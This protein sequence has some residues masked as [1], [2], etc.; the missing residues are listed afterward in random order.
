MGYVAF[1]IV[2]LEVQPGEF[3]QIL[4]ESD[5]YWFA[6]STIGC[7]PQNLKIQI[8]TRRRLLYYCRSLANDT[9][10]VHYTNVQHQQGVEDYG[11]IFS[12]LV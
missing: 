1:N 3:V 6:L 5:N 7:E 2:G 10:T 11:L 12:Q 4:N 9:I 8:V